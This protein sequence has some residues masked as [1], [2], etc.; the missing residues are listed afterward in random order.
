MKDKIDNDIDILEENSLS[1]KRIDDIL[2]DMSFNTNEDR[3]RTKYIIK[4]M[5]KSFYDSFMSGKCVQIPFIGCIRFNGI[6]YYM[7]SIH[8]RLK[9]IRSYLSKSEFLSYTKEIVAEYKK[10]EVEKDRIKLYFKKI[11]AANKKK[12]KNLIET[13][14]ISYA[15][16]YIYSIFLLKEVAHSEEFE[17]KIRELNGEIFE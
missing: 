5:E 9:V 13:I 8:K 1:T 14:G 15:N 17:I 3:E 11:K 4:D 16:M 2:D 6:T 10:N 7:R 12:Y